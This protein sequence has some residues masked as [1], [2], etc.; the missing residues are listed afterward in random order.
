MTSVTGYSQRDIARLADQF[1]QC[2]CD[3]GTPRDFL[4]C[5]QM[6]QVAQAINETKKEVL[7][8]RREVKEVNEKIVNACV[9]TGGIVGATGGVIITALV[10]PPLAPL[11]KFA[12]ILGGGL[13][14]GAAGAGIG[15]VAGKAMTDKPVE[16]KK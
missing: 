13:V 8:L 16:A 6:Q 1:P 7:D 12:S 15:Y 4:N 5:V 2:A 11:Y 14:G 3:K 9:I 10:I